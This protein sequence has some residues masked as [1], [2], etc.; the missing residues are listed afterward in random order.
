M[1]KEDLGI[2]GI[3]GP[4]DTKHMRFIKDQIEEIN[5]HKWVEGVKTGS[6]PGEQ[7]CRDWV[8]KYA[9]IFRQEWIEKHGNIEE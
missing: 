8:E 7:A 4:P 5:K 1:N 9:P 6:D 3:C 2:T